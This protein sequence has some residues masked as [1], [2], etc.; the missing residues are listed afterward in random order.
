MLS[1]EFNALQR[2]NVQGTLS[3]MN[4][5]H[6]IFYQK[7]FYLHY[8]ILSGVVSQDQSCW[9]C[10]GFSRQFQIVILRVCSPYPSISHI[11]ITRS[12]YLLSTL[13]IKCLSFGNQLPS[14]DL[15]IS[16]GPSLDCKGN[17]KV[18]LKWILLKDHKEMQHFQ[19]SAQISSFIDFFIL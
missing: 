4:L 16:R 3:K 13:A 8:P 10:N 6:Y 2:L 11:L 19:R 7:L 18:I 5:W 9:K 15:T 1:S 17:R 12:P 14:R